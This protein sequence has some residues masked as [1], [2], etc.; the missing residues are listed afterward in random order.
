MLFILTVF[1]VICYKKFKY[2]NIAILYSIIAALVGSAM[3]IASPCVA[4]ISWDEAIHYSNTNNM[5]RGLSAEQMEYDNIISSTGIS[6]PETYEENQN[7]IKTINKSDT[8]SYDILIG[9][10]VIKF[11]NIIYVPMALVRRVAEIIGVSPS[12]VFYIGKFVSLIIFI[13]VM[14]YSIHIAKV[15][16][17]SLFVLGLIPITVFHAISYSRDGLIIAGI[18]LS[19]VAFINI[20]VDKKSKVDFKFVALFIL[21]LLIACL[22]KP[23]YFPLFLV[24]LFIPKDRFKN[25]KQKVIF[26]FLLLMITL[27]VVSTFGVDL[28]FNNL[29]MGDSRGAGHISVAEQIDVVLHNPIG[30]I[31][32]FIKSFLSTFFSI[33]SNHIT[34]LG[35]LGNSSYSLGYV[36]VISLI[37]SLFVKTNSEEEI[38]VQ[39]RYKLLLLF[40]SAVVI[41]GINLALYLEFTAVGSNYIDGVQF[42]YYLPLMY[43]L[44]VCIITPKI[45]STFNYKNVIFGIS[46]AC[47]IALY[48]IIF[49]LYIWNIYW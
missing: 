23:N 17:T 16:K 26:S 33:F 39:G 25:N 9:T 30:F 7:V 28:I 8:Y 15:G 24:A 36:F 41:F 20:I 11:D 14:T 12:I 29:I 4:Q 21:P 40:I 5:F 1:L 35:Y 46:L 42:R 44:I 27:L 3:I 43:M 34:T 45:K 48:I 38:S 47:T 37:I 10:H 31:N 2:N 49:E 18:T 22:G 13:L 32:I 6:F 19:M